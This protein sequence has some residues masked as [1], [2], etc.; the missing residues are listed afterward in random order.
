MKKNSKQSQLFLV[1]ICLAS[2]SVASAGEGGVDEGDVKQRVSRGLVALYD[3]SEATGAMVRDRAGTKTPIDLKIEDLD[4]VRRKEGSLVVRGK[5][6][7]SSE[8]PPKRLLGAIRKSRAVTIEA[9]L[10]PRKLDLTGPAR[11]VT[12]SKDSVNRNFTL[13]QDGDRFDVRF[14]TER[15]SDNG[16]PSTASKSNAVKRALT[17]VVYTR[18]RDGNAKI[19][20]NGEADTSKEVTGSLDNWDGESRLALANEINKSRAW[21]GT[22]H[23]VAIYRRA[24]SADEIQQNFAAGAGVVAP[25]IVAKKPRDPREAH[26]ELAVAPI[27]ANQCLEC[28][29]SLANKGGLDLS[30]KVAALRGGDSG[31]AIVARDSAESLLWL[32]IESD[33][34]PHERPPLSDRDKQTIKKWIDDGAVWSLGTI[35]PAVYVHG[36]RPDANWLRR[37]T[38]PEYIETVRTLF[39]IDISAEAYELLPPDVRADGFSNTAYN[40]NVDLKHIEA[41]QKLAEIIVSRIDVEAFRQRFKKNLTFTDNGMGDLIEKMGRQILRGPLK[42]REVIAFRGISTTIAATD[43][44]NKE[45]AVAL[46]I[47]AMLQSPRFLYRIERQRGDGSAQPIDEYEL[48]S[49]ISYMIWGGPPDEALFRAANDGDLYD[50]ESILEHVM[51]MLDD[52]RAKTHSERFFADWLNLPRLQNLQPNQQKFPQWDP[53]LA[54]DMQKETVAFFRDVVWKQNRPLSDLLNAKVTFATPRLAKHYGL[55]PEAADIANSDGEL[56]RFDLSKTDARG[57]MLTQGSLLTVGGDEASMVTRGLLVMH[58]LLRGVVKDPPPCVD[59]TPVPTKAGLSQR[60]I[61]EGRLANEGCGGCH[62]RFEPLAFGLEKF[63]GLGGYHDKDEHG[64]A[65]RD[66][67][68]IVFPGSAKL[69]RYNST[70]ELMDLM[71]ASERVKESITW[72]LTQFALGR[73]LTGADSSAVQA[74]HATAQKNGGTYKAIMTAIVTSELVTMIQTDRDENQ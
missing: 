10:T 35:D 36:G 74:I 65:L 71:A 40:L 7:I 59:T 58:E 15:T 47:E 52:D 14:R 5:T 31:E 9:W 20:L 32:S 38:I 48:A 66:D 63:D 68:E 51:R 27:L 13:G 41:Y 28:H 1:V 61:A 12:L 30:R 42:T 33:E 55:P 21:L 39:N 49:R 17:H 34:M 3:F 43:D 29:D 25:A 50:E 46:L 60:V 23:L 57:G 73:P 45:E 16:I 8:R 44:G 4:Q 54:A 18:D 19:W 72:K 67:G 70:R 11:I 26:F 64:N 56:V 53:A 2:V 6:L 62:S 69:V 24:L 22:Y 37:L